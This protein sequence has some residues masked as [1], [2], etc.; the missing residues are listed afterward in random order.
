MR[1]TLHD[2]VTGYAA[3]TVVACALSAKRFEHTDL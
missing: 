3:A 2:L 1:K